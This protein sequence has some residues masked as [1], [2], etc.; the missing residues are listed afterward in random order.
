MGLGKVDTPASAAEAVDE[1]P[2]DQLPIV[3]PSRPQLHPACINRK[4]HDQN[5]DLGLEGVAQ[6][7]AVVMRPFRGPIGA[8]PTPNTPTP[9]NCGAN[10]AGAKLG[11][12]P[13]RFGILPGW[14]WDGVN[15]GTN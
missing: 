14:R 11:L 4:F 7:P 15:R 8:P 9:S 10:L 1:A 5:S 3:A 13:N 12:A 6:H 2:G